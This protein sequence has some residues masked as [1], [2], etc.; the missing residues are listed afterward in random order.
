MEQR[1]LLTFKTIVDV[2]GFKKA[3]ERLGYAQSSVTTHIKELEK[4]MEIPLFDRLGKTVILT[5]AGKRFYPF[6]D[7]MINLYHQSIEA[8]RGDEEYSGTLIVGVSESLMIYWLPD[9][10]PSFMAKYPAIHLEVKAIDYQNVTQQLKRGDYDIVLFV[11][12]SGWQSN[13]LTIKTLTE[14]KLVLVGSSTGLNKPTSEETMFLPER[15]CSWRPVFEEYL[16]RAG[17]RSGKTIELPSI[18][19]IKQC[20]MSGLGVSLLPFFAVKTEIENGKLRQ[21]EIEIPDEYTGIY[22]A[23]HKNKWLPACLTIFLEE[24]S[25][26]EAKKL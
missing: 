2:G 14:S 3:A 22:T 8:V 9:F 6:V 25:A 26:V 4:E 20:V 17:E 24:L 10:I 11:E 15:S 23:Y 18:E 1:Q 5:E 7:E 16:Q 19:S 21:S 12:M 13:E